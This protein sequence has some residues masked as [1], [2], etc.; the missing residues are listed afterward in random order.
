MFSL[1]YVSVATQPFST[2]ELVTL[3]EQARRNNSKSDITGMLLYKDGNF[4]QVLEGDEKK[5]GALQ[6]RISRDPRHHKMFTLA[7]G[8]CAAREF[9]DWSMGFSNL[10]AP[11]VATVAGYSEF[12]NVPLTEETFSR[13]PSRAQRLLRVFKQA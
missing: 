9:P 12:M 3:L 1:I 4:L 2:A 13:S 6:H 10:D 8:T 11:E 7:Q 5:V